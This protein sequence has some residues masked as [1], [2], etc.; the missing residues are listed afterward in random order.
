MT[1]RGIR[2]RICK[3]LRSSGFDYKE[4]ILL[5]YVARR[6]G[7]SNMVVVPARHAENRF[8]G[9]LKGLQIRA[10]FHQS[11][12]E[13]RIGFTSLCRPFSSVSD[14]KQYY[15]IC[16]GLYAELSSFAICQ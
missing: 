16:Q 4:P 12:T 14:Y 5:A 15:F 8:L 9:S 3:R 6:A 13:R 1:V 7:T 10:L 11:V 2:A